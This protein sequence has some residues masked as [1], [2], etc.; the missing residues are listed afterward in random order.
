LTVDIPFGW[1]KGRV[2]RWR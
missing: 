2:I 1:R